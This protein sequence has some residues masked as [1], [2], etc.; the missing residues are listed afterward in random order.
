MLTFSA[1]HHIKPITQEFP[2]MVKGIK[3]AMAK[4]E[5]GEVRYQAVLVAGK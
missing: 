3:E 1:L 2:F 5:K 4:L